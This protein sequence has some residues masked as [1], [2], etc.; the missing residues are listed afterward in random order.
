MK[1]EIPEGTNPSRCR[2]CGAVIY[3]VKTKLRKNMPVNHDGEPHWSNC[4]HAK[5]WSKKKQ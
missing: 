5:N 3:W 2:S 4:P 1:Y